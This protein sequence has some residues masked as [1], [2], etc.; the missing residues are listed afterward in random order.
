MFRSCKKAIKIFSSS[1]DEHAL[2]CGASDVIVVK[3]NSGHF[4]STR[5]FA[6]FGSQ[7]LELFGKSIKVLVNK[8]LINNLNFS[9]NK[10]GYLH[11]TLFESDC[12]SK[13]CLRYGRNTIEYCIDQIV[14][15]AEIYLYTEQDRL[16]ISD[17][18][19]T[20]TKNDIGGLYNNYLGK[21]YLHDGYH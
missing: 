16:L 4:K 14:L 19:G 9:I 8:I 10:Y 11:P 2:L 17:F 5:F 12:L 3:D 6:C 7:S 21:D 15:S 1:L 13:L 18:D 20:A